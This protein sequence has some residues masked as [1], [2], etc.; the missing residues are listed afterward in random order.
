[1]LSDTV[2]VCKVLYAVLGFDDARHELNAKRQGRRDPPSLG[3]A[4][5]PLPTSSLSAAPIN[6]N[7]YISLEFH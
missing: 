6:H 5:T 3:F 2:D 7:R 4:S 1:L